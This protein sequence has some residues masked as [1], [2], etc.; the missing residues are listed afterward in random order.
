MALPILD[1][2]QTSTTLATTISGGAHY[3]NHILASAV[4]ISS[5]PNAVL[6]GQEIAE[7]YDNYGGA[8]ISIVSSINIPVSGSV[9]AS[10]SGTS[11]VTGSTSILNFPATQT[12][13][14]T[15]IATHGVTIGAGTAQ[16]GSVTISSLPTR[17]DGFTGATG[18]PILGTGANNTIRIEGV[19]TNYGPADMR[20]GGGIIAL[21]R[22]GG[23]SGSG[24]DELRPIPIASN[25]MSVMISGTVT[26]NSGGTST[27]TFGAVSIFGTPSVTMGAISGIVTANISGTVPV[28]GTFWQTTQPVSLASVPTHGVTIGAGT[29]QIGSVTASIS[30]TVPVSGT[31]YQATQP[32]SI[33]SLP[34]LSAGSAQI[35]S[36]TASISGTPSV[37]FGAITGSVNILGTPSITFGVISGTVT[38]NPVYPRITFID[39]SGSVVTANSAIQI[40]AS[41]TT[42]SYLLVQVTTGSAYVNVGAT[43]TTANGIYLGT[44]Q[45][46]AWETTIPQGIVSLISSATGTAYCSKEA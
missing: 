32:V 3:P 43:A 30:G 17:I 7:G 6:F 14:F 46:Y 23:N 10:I 18:T 26:A 33:A 36:V 9:T 1:G 28:S 15:Q 40:F 8:P 24:N 41:S 35:G 16:I 21:G 34:S 19:T 27:V 31:F 13:T 11:V 20:E 39:G 12:V 5:F 25:G 29:A 45:G 4:T 22:T 37:T 38:A 2:N 44:G 42:R